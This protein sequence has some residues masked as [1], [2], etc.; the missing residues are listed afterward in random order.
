MTSLTVSFAVGVLVFVAVFVAG[1]LAS[2]DRPLS[3]AWRNE[4]AYD[5]RGDRQGL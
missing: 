4:A 3:P 2:T 5:R 1:W